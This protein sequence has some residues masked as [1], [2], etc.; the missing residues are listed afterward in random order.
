MESM[1]KAKRILQ[2][3]SSEPRIGPR[4]PEQGGSEGSLPLQSSEES[5]GSRNIAARGGARSSESL[6]LRRIVIEGNGKI[7]GVGKVVCSK[8]KVLG[9]VAS[10]SDA[11]TSESVR[12]LAVMS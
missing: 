12:N 5:E 6:L 8:K 10:S 2:F 1:G 9:T 11:V 4:S 3:P 7:S